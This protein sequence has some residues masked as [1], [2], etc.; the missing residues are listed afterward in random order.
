MYVYVRYVPAGKLG[1]VCCRVIVSTGVR[2]FLYRC[3]ACHIEELR[4][5]GRTG[6]G[7]TVWIA[8]HRLKRDPFFVA[9]AVPGIL[10]LDS[11]NAFVPSIPA[12]PINA[13]P[14]DYIELIGP[15][16]LAAALYP[17]TTTTS[18]G[19]EGPATA[20]KAAVAVG[21][22]GEP[23][24]ETASSHRA[25]KQQQQQQQQQEEEEEQEEDAGG[26]SGE[27][28]LASELLPSLRRE[29]MLREA[30][31]QDRARCEQTEVRT[32]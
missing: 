29:E 14:T 31:L 15:V 16:Q 18:R 3:L 30:N 11:S 9:W 24:Q 12:V 25:G 13:T 5:V 8:T 26:C 20:S 1:K 7:G 17:S 23:C 6:W 21:A 2:L 28:R 32:I 10:S 19:K 4:G 27:E 22:T